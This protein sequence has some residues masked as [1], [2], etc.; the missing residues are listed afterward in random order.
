M[1]GTDQAPPPPPPPPSAPTARLV[2]RSLTHVTGRRG[3]R[4]ATLALGRHALRRAL[5]L[6]RPFRYKL[7]PVGL[8]AIA[9]LPAIGFLGIASLLPSELSGAVLPSAADFYG[10][11]LVAVILFTSLAGPQTLCPDRRY[12]TLGLYLASPLDRTRYLAANAGAIA[13]VLLVVTLG[14][15]LLVTLGLSFLGVP[16]PAV[17]LV[18]GRALLSSFVFASVFASV[19]LAGS[20]V[21]DRRAF[22]SAGIFVALFGLTVV[23]EVL[24]EALNVGRAITLLD[25]TNVTV[26]LVARIHGSPAVEELAGVATPAI[27]GAMLA[28]V[29]GLLAFVW[30]RY[31]HLAV[32]R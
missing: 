4:A 12:R 3:T 13:V 26:E 30:W 14:P 5:G 6:R 31:R 18:I 17:L 23:T 28:W 1:S 15:P 7:L 19:A 11:T 22:A 32:V 21:T 9:Y 27:V 24:R 20:A 2:D 29:A 8:A 10:F 25:P 16:G